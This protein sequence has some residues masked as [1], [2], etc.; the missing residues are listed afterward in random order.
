MRKRV[1]LVTGGNRGIG[2]ESCR[3]LA[4]SGFTVMLTARN[5]IKGNIAVDKLANKEGL[6]VIFHLLD[7][8]NRDHIKI[9]SKK[10]QQRYGSLDVLVNNAAILYDTWQ[11]TI[12]TDLEVVN[13]AIVTNV[14]GPWR[15]CQAFYSYHEKK[16]IWTH[17]KYIQP[18]GFITLYAGRRYACL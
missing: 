7:V 9:M 11:R 16:W 3:Q 10:V 13:Q 5:P 18:W 6:D 2:F 15:L 12:D 17:S 8:T 1:A 4:R 14:Y